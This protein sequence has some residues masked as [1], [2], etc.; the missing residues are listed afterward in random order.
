[1]YG[2]HYPLHS[3]NYMKIRVIPKLMSERTPMFR[4]YSCKFRSEEYKQNCARLSLW[5]D[6]KIQTSLTI[7]SSFHGYL[8]ENRETKT[9]N[10]SNLQYFGQA[11]CQSLFE[12]MLILEENK[13]QKLALAK[14]LSKKRKFQKIKTI[15][16]ILGL[17]DNE[18]NELSISDK[19]IYEEKDDKSLSKKMQRSH[20]SKS[21]DKKAMGKMFES[22]SSDDCDDKKSVNDK[23]SDMLPELNVSKMYAQSSDPSLTGIENSESGNPIL[24]QNPNEAEFGKRTVNRRIIIER[25][26]VTKRLSGDLHNNVFQRSP[27]HFN[28]DRN[29]P[30]S[31]SG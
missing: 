30:E 29:N 24:V 13:K 12:Y 23:Q 2:P 1:M 31:T 28:R 16:E 4:F 9:F 17:N 25:S 27:S 15:R 10:E 5:R 6:F 19:E 8:D 11:F 18:L 3:G 26:D 20:K 14:K 22:S 7:E 21:P